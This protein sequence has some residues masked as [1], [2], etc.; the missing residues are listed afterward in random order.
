MT[1][2]AHDNFQAPSAFPPVQMP[3]CDSASTLNPLNVDVHMCT[4]NSSSLYSLDLAIQ[5]Q[6]CSV[7]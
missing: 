2:E 3:G 5:T 1:D 7:I 6:L 4:E